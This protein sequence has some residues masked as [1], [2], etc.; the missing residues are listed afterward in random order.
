MTVKLLTES[1]L[2]ATYVEA[3]RIWDAQKEQGVSREERLS[4]LEQTLKSAWPQ[5]REWKYLCRECSDY[6]LVMSTCPG[7]AT[8]G[9]NHTHQPHEFGRPCWCSNGAKFRA[10]PETPAAEKPV[11]K[12]TKMGR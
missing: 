10:T 9:R 7:D 8:C 3:L 1:A 5:T 11:R 6:G 2:A 4:G 12:P